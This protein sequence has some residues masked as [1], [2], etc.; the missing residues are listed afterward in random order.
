MLQLLTSIKHDAPAS[1]PRRETRY[2][3]SSVIAKV[4]RM[5]RKEFTAKQFAELHSVDIKTAQ[6][7]LCDAIT[8]KLVKRAP[9]TDGVKFIYRKE[10]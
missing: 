2:L 5:R 4:N 3:E 1:K 6:R 8:L 7:I 10:S 9:G